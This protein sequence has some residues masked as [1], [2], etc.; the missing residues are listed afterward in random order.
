MKEQGRCACSDME[1]YKSRTTVE[2]IQ[3]TPSQI[4]FFFMDQSQ[5]IAE[6][7]NHLNLVLLGH[8]NH[9]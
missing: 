9:F 5:I 1:A 8:R 4:D 7:N 2:R 6:I 3:F